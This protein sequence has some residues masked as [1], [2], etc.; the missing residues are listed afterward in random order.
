M[1]W[2][3]CSD[4]MDVL[5]AAEIRLEPEAHLT[6]VNLPSLESQSLLRGRSSVPARIELLAATL[7]IPTSF[8][9]FFLGPISTQKTS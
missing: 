6:V 9:N 1:Q 4:V 3:Y 8:W 5:W 2:A 7:H